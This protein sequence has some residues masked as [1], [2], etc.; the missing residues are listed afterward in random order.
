MKRKRTKRV[1]V[2]LMAVML[3]MA[4][5]V[6]SF[7]IDVGMVDGVLGSI[8]RPALQTVTGLT[9]NKDKVYLSLT[10]EYLSSNGNLYCTTPIVKRGTKEVTAEKTIT[11]HYVSAWAD[12]GKTGRLFTT[13]IGEN[14]ITGVVKDDM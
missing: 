10:V 5:S 9:R 3:L 14:R 2:M 13:I 8:S 7:A 4:T 6:T 12:H 11:E 1:M